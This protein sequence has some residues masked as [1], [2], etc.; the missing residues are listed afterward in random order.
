MPG[1]VRVERAGFALRLDPEAGAV[2]LRLPEGPALDLVPD[3]GPAGTA[4]GGLPLLARGRIKGPTGAAERLEL[5]RAGRR[6]AGERTVVEV[7]EDGSGL[8]VERSGAGAAPELVVAVPPRSGLTARHL[9]LGGPEDVLVELGPE[10]GPARILVGLAGGPREGRLRVVADGGAL[11]VLRDGPARPDPAAG[12]PRI[13]IGVGGPEAALRAAWAIR[14]GAELGAGAPGRGAVTWPGARPS[15]ALPHLAPVA[16]LP[17]APE[18]GGAPGPAPDG[19]WRLAEDGPWRLRVGRAQAVRVAD[20]LRHAFASRRLWLNAV[21]P[22][23]A[24]GADLARARTR[25]ALAGLAGGLVELAAP[26]DALPAARLDLLRRA[27][28]PLAREADAVDDRTLRV[29]LLGGRVAILRVNRADGARPLGLDLAALGLRGPHHVFDFFAERD[30]G[31]C[32]DRVPD[33][34][35]PPGGCRLLGVTPPADR[36]QVVGSTLHVGMGTLEAAA[37]RSGGR[38]APLRLVLRHPGAHRGAVF[39][40]VPGEPRARRVPVAFRDEAVVEVP[41]PG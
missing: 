19:A 40:A 6:A 7:P 5:Q 38:G 25:V 32:R 39:V 30:L 22:L 26:P 29:P 36:P 24:D 9:P 11:Q 18:P 23:D 4:R 35:V 17:A 10:G 33:A 27:L 2:R 28:P 3:A 13:W 21:G 14:T 34:P 41:A 20:P 1:P 8:L 37:L 12:A 31:P 16:V 15:P